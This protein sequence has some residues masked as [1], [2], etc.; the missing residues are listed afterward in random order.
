MICGEAWLSSGSPFCECGM[1]AAKVDANQCEI[2][3][4]FRQLGFSVQT[5]HTVG[6]GVPDLL[7]GKHGKNWLIEVKDGVKKKLT[8]DQ[9]KWH[10][11]WKG[12]VIVIYSK[13]QAIEFARSASLVGLAVG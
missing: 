3:D 11:E 5:L 6:Q 1:R 7:I 13:D 2:V 4:C 9:E 8:C 12:Q 10:S